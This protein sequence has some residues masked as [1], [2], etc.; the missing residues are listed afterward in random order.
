MSVNVCSKQ[1]KAAIAELI[2]G[3]RFSTAFGATLS[4][5]VPPRHR[6]APRRDAA[7]VPAAGRAARP[8]R[9][10]EGHLRHRHAR[11]GHQRADPHR[12]VLGVVGSTTAP[13]AGCSTPGSSTRSPGGPAGRLRHRR[14]RDRPG[15]RPRGGEPQASSPRSPTIPKKRRKLVRRKGT[16]GHGAVERGHHDPAG[17]GGPGAADVEHAD[18]HRDAARRRRPPRGPVRR[19]APAAHRQPRAPQAPAA[20]HPR[21]GRHRTLAAAGRGDRAPDSRDPTGGATG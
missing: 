3:F 15:T 20:A 9:A 6:G 12:R 7:Q 14:D 10:A 16:G 13:A 11:G 8:G 2:G 5:L 1:E 18:L 21:G 17:R 19:D 4:R